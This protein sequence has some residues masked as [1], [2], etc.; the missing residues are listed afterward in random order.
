LI[1]FG[2]LQPRRH[3]GDRPGGARFSITARM[4]PAVSRPITEIGENDWVAIKYPHAI[5]DDEEERWVSD[6]EFAEIGSIAFTSRRKSEHISARLIVSRV[7]RL[8]PKT[9]PAGQGALFSTWRHHAVFTDSGVSMLAAEATHRG[10][11][12]VEQIIAGLK[13]GPLAHMPPRRST[14]TPPGRDRVQPH[15]RH[16]HPR[17]TVPRKGAHRDDPRPVHRLVRADRPLRPPTQ[18]PPT[19]ALA[20][21]TTLAPIAQRAALTFSSSSG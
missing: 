6:A 16:R 17:I 3:R 4:D 11:A 19:A 13:A 5:Y 7:K 15:P 14:P 1:R 9:V 10:H 12:I 8:N 20:L 2:V 21:G 18:N